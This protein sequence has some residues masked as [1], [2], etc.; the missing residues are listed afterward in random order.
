MTGSSNPKRGDEIS[1]HR[2]KPR[3]ANQRSGGQRRKA[4]LGIGRRITCYA[5]THPKFHSAAVLSRL[6]G[7]GKH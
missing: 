4:D 2:T 1:P 3:L 7:E 6:V 5:S